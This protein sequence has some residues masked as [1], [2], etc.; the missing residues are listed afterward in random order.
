MIKSSTFEINDELCELI[1][2]TIFLQNE[3]NKAIFYKA[4]KR[5]YNS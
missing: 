1:K 5:V 4:K 2:K 3:F